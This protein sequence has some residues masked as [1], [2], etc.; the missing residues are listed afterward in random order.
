MHPS[1]SS[2]CPSRIARRGVALLESLIAFVFLCLGAL[3]TVQLQGTL[4][5]HADLARQRSEAVRLGERELEALRAF[6]VVE[7][8]SGA[9]AYAAIIDAAST[10]DSASGY[11]SNTAY[12]IVRH[13]DDSVVAGAKAATVAVEW[14]GRDG[15]LQRVALDSVIARS[16][17]AYSGA[18]ALPTAP[19]RGAFSRSPLIPIG[20]RTLGDGR[21]AWRPAPGGNVVLVFDDS[22]GSIVAKCTGVAAA[23]RDI[24]LGDLGRCSAG[25]WLLLSGTVR[26]TSAVPPLAATASETPLPVTALLTLA[27]RSDSDAP[28]CSVDAMKTVRYEASGSLHFAAVPIDAVPAWLG[29]ADWVDSGDRY[30]AYRC[31]VKPRADGRW[32][33]R[34]TLEPKG[35]T[36]GSGS[37][38]RRVCRFSSDLDGSGAID[39]NIEHPAAYADVAGTLTA[40]NFLVVR[41]NQSC[42]LAADD[43]ARSAGLGTVQQ[44]P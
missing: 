11:L 15:T 27:E 30:A 19:P 39:A 38:D 9:R 14:T 17:P 7:A 25:S 42:P 44:Q 13:I 34:T 2:S 29:L 32:S 28:E 10:V 35:W 4:R 16:D 24:A 1:R 8:A 31:I 21:S 37:A 26:F 36:I 18:L 3:A 12:R 33:G 5:L 22:S 23:S 6:S 40:Q 20:A 41:G 43:G